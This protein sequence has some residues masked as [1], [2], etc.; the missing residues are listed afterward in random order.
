MEKNVY[1]DLERRLCKAENTA[2]EFALS[3]SQYEEQ[4]LT[5]NKRISELEKQL[6]KS[7]KRAEIACSLLNTFKTSLT[8]SEKEQ[9]RLSFE[10]AGM[11]QKWGKAAAQLEAHEV[12]VRKEIKN[13][14]YRQALIDNYFQE[15][16]PNLWNKMGLQDKLGLLIKSVT[17][18][19]TTLGNTTMNMCVWCKKVLL[20]NT[21]IEEEFQA[22]QRARK[23]EDQNKKAQGKWGSHTTHLWYCLRS[24]ARQILVLE[25]ATV[26]YKEDRDQYD[27]FIN[28]VYDIEGFIPDKPEDADK[29]E[30]IK[31]QIIHLVTQERMR[32]EVCQ[33]MEEQMK[34]TEKNAVQL[35]SSLQEQLV[36]CGQYRN[37]NQSV[38]EVNKQKALLCEMLEKVRAESKG[39]VQ[40]LTENMFKIDTSFGELVAVSS[41]Q[42]RKLQTQQTEIDKMQKRLNNYRLK[43]LELETK[44]KRLELELG[45]PHVNVCAQCIICFQMHGSWFWTPCSHIF[46]CK[47]C[48][49][50]HEKM[51]ELKCPVCGIV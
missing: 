14:R 22:I 39:K 15:N 35:F 4:Q 31:R 26:D 41:D 21:N 9:K 44:H 18:Y 20:K 12:W 46:L 19:T 1:S 47:A 5:A 51:Q 30:T 32:Q 10:L 24:M 28:M 42:S 33:K 27:K 37:K 34:Q 48:K 6:K 36:L 7:E 50:G 29:Q 45:H 43:Y 17:H 40:E 11:T 13:F 8:F 25:Q 16:P 49:D 3:F 2:S 38:G 23:P